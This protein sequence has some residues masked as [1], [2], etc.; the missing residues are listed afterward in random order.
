M[1]RPIL[2]LG[3]IVTIVRGTATA[4]LLI[5]ATTSAPFTLLMLIS[6]MALLS[7]IGSPLVLPLLVGPGIFALAAVN[8]GTKGILGRSS[9]WEHTERRS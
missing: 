2:P 5:L 1:T 8:R 3:G 9:L 6:L 7:T 4:S